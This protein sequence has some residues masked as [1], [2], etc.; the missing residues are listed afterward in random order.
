RRVRALRRRQPRLQQHSVQVPPAHRGLVAGA[1]R[2]RF[3]AAEMARRYALARALMDEHELDALVL[4]GNSGVNRHNNVNPFW[5]S[6]YLDMHHSYLVVPRAEDAEPMLLVALVNHVPNAREVSDVP[7]IEWAGYE[8]GETVAGRLTAVGITRGRA[9]LVGVSA[10]WTMGMPWQHYLQLRELLPDVELVDV[11]REYSRLRA[12]K[13]EEEI[14]RLRGAA[15]L[16]DVA[17]LALQ[18]AAK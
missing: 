16:T 15:G 10:T 11:T 6:Q 5:L 3:S 2:V 4:F 8:A 1:T 9:G 12:V 18:K 14:E 13:S 17:I 7:C